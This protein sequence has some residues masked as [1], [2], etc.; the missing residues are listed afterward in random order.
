M[1]SIGQLP[2][3]EC[4]GQWTS[5]KKQGR[6]IESESHSQTSCSHGHQ[7]SGTA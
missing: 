2:V 3:A 5:I 1:R 7:Q 4:F 6:K